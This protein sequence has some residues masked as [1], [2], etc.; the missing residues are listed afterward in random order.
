MKKIA[1]CA[2]LVFVLV[3]C[4]KKEKDPNET[5]TGI[6]GYD[7]TLPSGR[8]VNR[9]KNTKWEIPAYREAFIQF[10]S[11]GVTLGM[12]SQFILSNARMTVISETN[13]V[14]VFTVDDLT[15]SVVLSLKVKDRDTLSIAPHATGGDTAASQHD[16]L[17]QD[18]KKVN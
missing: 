11:E 12:N 1:F 2:A 18:F 9:L 17:A 3:A 15:N 4:G 6:P 7:T 16:V 13:D 5:N 10:T 8:M 14:L